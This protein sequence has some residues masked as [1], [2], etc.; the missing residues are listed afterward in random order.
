MSNVVLQAAKRADHRV[1][2]THDL[3]LGSLSSA[4]VDSSLINWGFRPSGSQMDGPWTS[5]MGVFKRQMGHQQKCVCVC[6]LKTIS[7]SRKH[8][9]LEIP[10]GPS[11]AYVLTACASR[12]VL[13][14]AQHNLRYLPSSIALSQLRESKLPADKTKAGT[15]K[16][17]G[18]PRRRRFTSVGHA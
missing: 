5:L 17:S 4:S 3:W 7:P 11:K 15:V 13:I 10:C 9:S 8:P 1:E 6:H 16:R 12:I 18:L 14:C 2:N